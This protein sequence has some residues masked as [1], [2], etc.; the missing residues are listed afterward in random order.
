MSD[1]D[2]SRIR[3]RR[4]RALINKA[5][6]LNRIGRREEALEFV[7]ELLEKFPRNE[8]LQKLNEQLMGEDS[9]EPNTI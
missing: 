6:L 3:K 8:R 2:R 9:A 5:I 4:Q 1:N 7:K